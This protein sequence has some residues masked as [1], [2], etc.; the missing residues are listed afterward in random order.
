M[1]CHFSRFPGL[2][3][4]PFV[5]VVTVCSVSQRRSDC[6]RLSGVGPWTHIDNWRQNVP[7]VPLRLETF[8][9]VAKK[10]INRFLAVVFDLDINI[11]AAGLR[12]LHLRCHFRCART[13]YHQ[14]GVCVMIVVQTAPLACGDRPGRRTGLR[15]QEPIPTTTLL[16]RYQRSMQHYRQSISSLVGTYI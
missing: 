15:R 2:Q 8:G 14:V 16:D 6:F 5:D 12:P 7:T 1:I 9:T 4:P 13:V 3:L 11:T 10:I